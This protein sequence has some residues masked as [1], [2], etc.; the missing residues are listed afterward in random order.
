MLQPYTVEEE[1]LYMVKGNLGF[2]SPCC[3]GFMAAIISV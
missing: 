3:T 1:F 2:V